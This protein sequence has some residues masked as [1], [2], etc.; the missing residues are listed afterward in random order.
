MYVYATGNNLSSIQFW[1]AITASEWSAFKTKFLEKLSRWDVKSSSFWSTMKDDTSWMAETELGLKIESVTN[2]TRNAKNHLFYYSILPTT[3]QMKVIP[4][5]KVRA[6][7]IKT[8]LESERDRIVEE[9]AQQVQETVIE[10]EQQTVAEKQQEQESIIQ[11]QEQEAITQQQVIEQQQVKTA[12][13]A[14]KNKMLQI[15]MVLV[16]IGAG[17]FLIPQFMGKK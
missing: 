5:I 15:A 4:A 17:I 2:Q 6:L 8:K 3:W 10:K 11:K 16:L 1:H 12:G 9:A 13:V 7:A 14:S